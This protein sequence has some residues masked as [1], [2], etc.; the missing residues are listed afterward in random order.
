[1]ED[2]EKLIRLVLAKVEILKLKANHYEWS[3]MV[4]DDVK[5]QLHDA[6][7]RIDTQ[8]RELE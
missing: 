5:E 7:S 8:I 3:C 4:P 6:E 1:M 2:D